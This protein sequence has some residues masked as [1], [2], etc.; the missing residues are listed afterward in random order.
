MVKDGYQD[1]ML[2]GGIDRNIGNFSHYIL[3]SVG[4]LNESNVDPERA[5]RPMDKNR[6][7]AIQGDGGGMLVLES[8]ESAKARKAPILAEI[9]GY[10]CASHADNIY[11]P[12]KI[13]YQKVLGEAIL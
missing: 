5:C 2:S 9:V 1:V 11:L 6:K 3:D 10:H 12:N 8:L 13:G 7:G 4:A